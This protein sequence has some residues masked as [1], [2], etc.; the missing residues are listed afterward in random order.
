MERKKKEKIS[1]RK[2][3]RLLDNDSQNIATD[4]VST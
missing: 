3:P 4:K 2:R 1:G